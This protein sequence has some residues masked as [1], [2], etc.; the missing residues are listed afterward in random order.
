[1][2]IARNHLRADRFGTKPHPCADMFLDRR[3]DIGEGADRA[4]DGAGCNLVAGPFQPGAT[5]RHLGMEPSEGQAHRG[6]FGMDAVAAADPQRVLVFIG[7]FLQCRQNAVQIGQQNVGGSHQLDVQRRVQ[8]VGR[9]H[10]LMHE[11]GV[12]AADMFGQMGQEGNHVM[13]GHGLDFIDPGNVELDVLRPPDRLRVLARD[14]A[15]IGLRVAGMSLDL[16]PDPELRLG[17]PDRGHVGAGIA[18]DHGGLLR[19]WLR[20][21]GV[22]GRGQDFCARGCGTFGR[23]WRL[24]RQVFPP[25]RGLPRCITAKTT[26]T[27]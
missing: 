17:R 3:I 22:A 18:R 16:E 1:M 27:T 11:A 13:F 2:A 26:R 24:I 14:H 21:S 6:R 10:A 20:H 9:G 7:A 15:Q 5:A 23:G 8:N 25:G 4:G 12:I 19:G